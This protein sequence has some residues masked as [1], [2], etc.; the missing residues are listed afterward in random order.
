MIY[1]FENRTPTLPPGNEFFVAET[2]TVIGSVRLHRHS[3]IWFGAVLRGDIEPIEVGEMSNIQDNS[4]VHTSH[5]FPVRIGKCVTVGHQVTLH[6]CTIGDNC[7]IGMQAT[8]L[9]GCKVGDNCLIGAGAL[10]PEG[11]V[12][13]EG[14]LVVGSPARMIGPLSE[15]RIAAIR[16]N[17]EHY[18]EYYQRYLNSTLRAL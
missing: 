18:V 16:H 10:I 6:G 12:I 8:L 11:K 5:D 7:L 2:A 13:P 15:E 1:Q 4:V 14:S 9:D 17:A 3:S